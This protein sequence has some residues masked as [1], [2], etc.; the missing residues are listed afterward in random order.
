MKMF[1]EPFPITDEVVYM[2]VANHG[3]PSTPVKKA[4]ETFLEDWDRLSRHG[5]VK[6]KEANASFAKLINADKEEVACQPNTSRGL[7]PVAA[8]LGLGKGDNVVTN[9]LENWAN[10]YPWTNLKAKG[11]EVR[12]VYGRDGAI[13]LEDIEKQVDDRTRVV[14]IS[15]VQWLTGARHHLKPLADLVHDHGGYL[16]VDGIQAAGALKVD[17]KREDVD[18]YACG[19]YKW[20]LG[21]SGAGF[22]YARRELLDR[23]HP[24][25][26]GYRAIKKHSLDGPTLKETAEKLEFGEPSYLS[27]V[28]TKASIDLMNRLGLEEIENQILKLSQHLYDGLTELCVKLVSPEDKSLRSGVVSFTTKDTENHFKA[29]KDE[30][31]VISL[32]PAGIRVSTGFYNTMEEVDKLLERLKTLQ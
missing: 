7:A 3:P 27:F 31:F 23:I 29:L 32:R 13:Q 10:V 9:D 25:E 1:R 8:S 5:D 28:G 18:F 30:G 6:V 11:V 21:P 17:V 16:V 20:L 4:I 2:N 19:S 14:S 22:L 26:Y 24:V 12:R 15:Q